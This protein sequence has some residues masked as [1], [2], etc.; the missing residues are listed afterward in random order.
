MFTHFAFESKH[1]NILD[2]KSMNDIR[3]SLIQSTFDQLFNVLRLS[4]SKVN[5]LSLLFVVCVC[6]FLLGHINK[7]LTINIMP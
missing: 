5:K 2:T 3:N 6:V 7:K 4:L 1:I